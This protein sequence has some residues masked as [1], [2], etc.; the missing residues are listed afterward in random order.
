MADPLSTEPAWIYTCEL[1]EYAK[2]QVSHPCWPS[3][4]YMSLSWT[5]VN[6]VLLIASLRSK[7]SMQNA[8]RKDLGYH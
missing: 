2:T 3:M 4:T 5:E 1:R 8:Q 7:N 6:V